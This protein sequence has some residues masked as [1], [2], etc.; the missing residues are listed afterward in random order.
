[1]TTATTSQHYR[2]PRQSIVIHGGVSHQ[3]VV[4][5]CPH[6]GQNLKGIECQTIYTRFQCP[7]CGIS[8]ENTNENRCRVCFSLCADSE[9]YN[10]HKHGGCPYAKTLYPGS[11]LFRG[12]NIAVR[13]P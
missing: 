10:S 12:E 4:K 7:E 8:I 5:T 9:T 13:Q 11:L 6:C 2:K 1:M 3:V